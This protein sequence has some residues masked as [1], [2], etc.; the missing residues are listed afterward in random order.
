MELEVGLEVELKVGF[1]VVVRPVFQ[2]RLTSPGGLWEW[3]RVPMQCFE[4]GSPRSDGFWGSIP[5]G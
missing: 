2:C 4:Y 3:C 5:Y 1:L